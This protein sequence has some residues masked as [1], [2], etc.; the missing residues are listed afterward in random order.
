MPTY[1]KR[2]V[3]FI[4]LVAF[5]VTGAWPGDL[6]IGKAHA[7]RPGLNNFNYRE[8]AEKTGIIRETL[9]VKGFDMPSTYCEIKDT[10]ETASEAKDVSPT[11][12][13]A[14]IHI[15]DAHCDYAAQLRISS[16]LE[17]LNKKYGVDRVYM[18]GGAGEYDL[19]VFDT[20]DNGKIKQAVAENFMKN[21]E[22]SGAEY[23]AVTNPGKVTLMGIEYPDLYIK[24]LDAYR[25]I[26]PY[27]SGARKALEDL[28][29]GL[30]SIKEA[31]L[32]GKLLGLYEKYKSYQSGNI[33]LEEYF[34]YLDERKGPPSPLD[35]GTQVGLRRDWFPNMTKLREVVSLENQIDFKKA[36]VERDM[37]IKE[38][39]KKL[40]LKE[41]EELLV[42][43]ADFKTGN[44]DD[45]DFYSYLL[46]KADCIC[47][48]LGVYPN[49]GKYS[50]YI[51]KYRSINNPALFDEIENAAREVWDRCS[52]N[53]LE[54][55]YFRWFKR[56]GVI[57][58]AV[59]AKLTKK[60]HDSIMSGKKEMDLAG[61]AGFI[62]LHGG[63][64]METGDIDNL[65]GYLDG[66]EKFYA[67]SFERDRSFLYNLKADIDGM[68]EEK[69]RDT[70]A[71][72]L[73]TG[74]FHTDNLASLMREKGIA[75]IS[76]MPKFTSDPD[77]PN[78]YYEILDGG[79][80]DEFM[81]FVKALGIGASLIAIADFGSSLARAARGDT[82]DM[83]EIKAW[84]E[85]KCRELG[86]IK[87]D[88]GGKTWFF[89][90]GS[91]GNVELVDP[92]G[93]DVSGFAE[94]DATEMAEGIL[95]KAE[96]DKDARAMGHGR[97]DI[98]HSAAANW[99]VLFDR[100]SLRWTKFISRTIF[101]GSTVFHEI[102]HIA[103]YLF[104]TG[105]GITEK[106]KKLKFDPSKIK[107]MFRDLGYADSDGMTRIP[108]MVSF[109]ADV[110]YRG[111]VRG[112]TGDARLDGGVAGNRMGA[113]FSLTALLL[114][115]VKAF[116]GQ[117]VGVFLPAMFCYVFAAN[118]ASLVMEYIAYERGT[119]DRSYY[120]GFTAVKELGDGVCKEISK[121]AI[122]GD[123]G[124]GHKSESIKKLAEYFHEY[125]YSTKKMVGVIKKMFEEL[126]ND[127]A[128]QRLEVIYTNLIPTIKILDE[129]STDRKE[130]MDLIIW[131]ALTA[132]ERVPDMRS[133]FDIIEHL[134]SSGVPSPEIE[135]YF[136]VDLS[137]TVDPGENTNRLWGILSGFE[138]N[139]LDM[140]W[141]E[142]TRYLFMELPKVLG[143]PRT[144]AIE[145]IAYTDKGLLMTEASLRAVI[146]LGGLADIEKYRDKVSSEMPYSN[147]KEN[148][149]NKATR[150]VTLDER[151]SVRDAYNE[152]W[153]WVP[154]LI[155]QDKD[156][157]LIE[158]I[159]G[160]YDAE[161]DL[162]GLD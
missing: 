154:S 141:K 67:S 9:T 2:L 71:V 132:P 121:S 70:K 117:D 53:P 14:I 38:L 88:A 7:E 86:G 162:L 153:Q 58:S 138:H 142:R 68:N 22:L 34:R 21:G 51:A 87:V 4:T 15:Q 64:V 109:F 98:A 48:D 105:D 19:S 95:A 37:I 63:K 96:T 97:G 128:L 101:L 92:A 123:V 127:A 107:N 131:G 143:I 114:I 74:G 59:N 55:E 45:R 30:D 161:G 12:D 89:N 129:T 144:K 41:I 124:W 103:S 150:K 3:S 160:V 118:L 1:F 61:L 83:L 40:S 77:I 102:G 135:R 108:G 156:K 60:D 157:R 24:N 90:M 54:K 73:I 29:A 137:G 13:I 44:I 134:I 115:A 57:D 139:D 79:F 31:S 78:P 148:E 81:K 52:E 69:R 5:I 84:L 113:F 158:A 111:N 75:Y 39:E 11:E 32:N 43:F 100:Q 27:R 8:L 10:F 122:L 136:K 42:K 46:G 99:D 120:G 126:K 149:I 72:V 50:G 47:L 93:R 17:Y 49:I 36:E 110:L 94:C 104:L 16:M 130:V 6:Y 76:L 151:Y 65:K 56:L 119:G 82:A 91:G 20:T 62:A 85:I 155:D 140:R 146:V 25:D 28:Y 80:S 26:L 145:R 35:E 18:E 106:G 116:T 66:M 152:L 112:I 133:F 33:G 147:F 125:G 23:Y 159:F